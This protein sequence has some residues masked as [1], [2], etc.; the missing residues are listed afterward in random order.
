MRPC[1]RAQDVGVQDLAAMLRYG[2]A[3]S[4]PAA[5]HT[6]GSSSVE[7]AASAA[8]LV[9][10]E[11]AAAGQAKGLPFLGCSVAVLAAPCDAAA[12]NRGAVPQPAARKAAAAASD[13]Q[14]SLARCIARRLEAQVQ[15]LALRLL[16]RACE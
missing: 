8:A 4:S 14:T 12:T 15:C 13:A 11:I 3:A 7:H 9:R 1:C 16:A 6:A 10:R 5:A 2:T